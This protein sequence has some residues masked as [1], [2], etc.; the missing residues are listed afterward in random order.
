MTR[1][2]TIRIGFFLLLILSLTLTSCQTT[3]PPAP[4][5][6]PGTPALQPT[7]TLLPVPQETATSSFIPQQ[8][9]LVPPTIS[10]APPGAVEPTITPTPPFTG[11]EPVYLWPA[12]MPAL[13]DAP[14]L[15]G[16]AMGIAN[17]RMGAQPWYWFAAEQPSDGKSFSIEGGTPSEG[18]LYDFPQGQTGQTE[19]DITVNGQA[20]KLYRWLDGGV[21][22]EWIT[23]ES[24]A[25]EGLPVLLSGAQLAEGELQRIAESLQPVG[26]EQFRTNLDENGVSI[27]PALTAAVRADGVTID[28]QGVNWPPDRPVRLIVVPLGTRQV[29]NFSDEAT[30]DP[31]GAFETT[32]TWQP[33]PNMEVLAVVGNDDFRAIAPLPNP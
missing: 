23:F 22:R 31:T 7:S 13:G 14:E 3:P 9:T 4:T 24:A 17:L 6:A 28:V 19:S 20:A 26:P 1:L 27:R 10:P 29:Q 25:S 18:T 32:M 12:T 2:A 16:Q 8:P 11:T 30:P 33:A 5:T 15:S 21:T